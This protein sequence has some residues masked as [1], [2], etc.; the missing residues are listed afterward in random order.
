MSIEDIRKALWNHPNSKVQDRARK[1]IQA[2]QSELD[3]KQA[4]IDELKAQLEDGAMDVSFEGS[5]VE[6]STNE[7]NRIGLVSDSMDLVTAGEKTALAVPVVAPC[8]LGAAELFNEED[9]TD[10][11]PIIITS[12]ELKPFALLSEID[13]DVLGA[14]SVSHLQEV[15]RFSFPS[16]EVADDTPVTLIEFDVVEPEPFTETILPF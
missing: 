14:E 12:L 6:E 2:H 9:E 3:A 8:S 16:F 15:I 11:I 5:P 1:L 10:V 7:A 4:R 13:A